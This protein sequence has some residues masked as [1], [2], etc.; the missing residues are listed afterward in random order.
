MGN[1]CVA[2]GGNPHRSDIVISNNTEH[3]LI[4]DVNQ[5]C[6]RECNHK[7]WQIVDG[8]IVE[9]FEPPKR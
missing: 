8:K 4:L 1:N 3:E 2:D 9:N 6:G 7:G 5:N